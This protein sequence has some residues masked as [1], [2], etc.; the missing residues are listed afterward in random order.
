M[1][2]LLYRKTALGL[3]P[4]TGLPVVFTV[5][6]LFALL[7]A[8]FALGMWFGAD[9]TE[10]R[11]AAEV[12]TAKAIAAR[13]PEGLWA[14][15][16]SDLRMALEAERNAAQNQ[17]ETASRQVTEM[18]TRVARMQA[19]VMR[20]EA[21]GARLTEMA[22]LATDE[23]DFSVAPAVGGPDANEEAIADSDSIGFDHA[24]ADLHNL[25][26]SLALREQQL[27]V[28]EQMLLN[29]QVEDQAEIKG[30]P[31]TSGWLSSQY[32]RRI[33]PFHGKRRM[34]NGIDFAGRE[35]SDIVAMGGGIVTWSGK[36][37]S[38]GKT[39]EINHPN[40]YVTRYAHL[41]EASVTAGSRIE[42]GAII[43]KMGQS[44]RSTGPHLHFEV[45]QDG[46]PVN[47]IKFISAAR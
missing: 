8:L 3:R 37:S 13:S 42:A 41:K 7:P 28:L 6:G 12:E 31:I 16:F 22:R 18:A 36:R 29:R 17:R 26:S 46:R 30:R 15:E 32:G 20:V 24:F 9:R 35:G 21:L 19:Q 23:F 39:V 40:G 27:V 25:D 45:L 5:A 1:S 43:G 34:H 47:P 10:E 44:G 2:I 14:K 4:F 38:Y 33:D 11:L